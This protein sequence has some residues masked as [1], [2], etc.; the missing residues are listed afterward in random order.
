MLADYRQ[1]RRRAQGANQG[2]R[3][4]ARLCFE[5]T[6]GDS[7]CIRDVNDVDLGR[8]QITYLG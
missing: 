1:R 5:G 7:K 6:E 4:I 3:G 2:H 8:G